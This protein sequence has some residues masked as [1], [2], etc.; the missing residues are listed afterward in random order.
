MSNPRQ[1]LIAAVLAWPLQQA[2]AA[3]PSFEVAAEHLPEV[4]MDNRFATLPL[5]D[6][7]HAAA[8]GWQLSVQAALARTGSGALRLGG[9][10]TAL[11]LQRPLDARLAVQAFAFVD[12]LRLS[13]GGD[14]RALDSQA[15]S[16]P[17]ALPA[18]ALFTD[19]Q[20]RYRD[21]GAGLAFKLTD[22]GRFG[23]QQWLAG[24]LLQR[25]SLRNDRA[26]YRVVQGASA[27]ATGV[28]DYSGSYTHVTPFAGLAAPR[29]LGAWDAVPY[30]LLAMPL[31]RRGVAGRISGPGFDVEGDT[32][33]AGHGR[34]FGD[35]SLSIGLDLGY[36]PWGLS[37]NLGSLLSQALVERWA[38]KG[39]DRNW[40][41]STTLR[42]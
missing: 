28:V 26:R 9:P 40:V 24:A 35:P 38:H 15:A 12:E 17:L 18:D 20:G 23:T 5:W 34:H 13:G 7:D 32:L 21:L 19:L 3:L 42:F 39:V 4:A 29:A 11:A 41:V 10:M 2:V 25:I 6:A 30:L 37:L 8:A 14:Q 22:H 36:R 1:L 31:P 27:G 33:S 16:V